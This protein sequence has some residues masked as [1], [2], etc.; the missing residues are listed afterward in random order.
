MH[1][2]Q[3]PGVALRHLRAQQ[4]SARD[5]I[6]PEARVMSSLVNS[7]LCSFWRRTSKKQSWVY[8][9]MGESVVTRMPTARTG[10]F[11]AS[12]LAW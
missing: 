10:R 12:Q 11:S 8:F 1:L 2:V 9:S 7:R 4:R 3:L 6:R 5:R